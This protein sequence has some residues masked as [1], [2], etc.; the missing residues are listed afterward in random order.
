MPGK[1]A[2]EMDPAEWRLYHPFHGRKPLST[3]TTN[4][5]EALKLARELARALRHRFAAR[6][7]VL[8]GSLARHDFSD[9]S[10][11]DLAVWGIPPG[12]FYRAV[13]FV[14]GFS[15]VWAVDLVDAEDCSESLLR[16]IE[17]EGV[18]L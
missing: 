15:K 4:A 11:I 7:V 6:K 18:E 16:S 2:F 14:C 8:F 5:A 9:R 3:E 10:D 12:Q 13:A 17:Q 1:T